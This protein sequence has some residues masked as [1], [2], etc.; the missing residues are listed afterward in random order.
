MSTPVTFVILMQSPAQ[1]PVLQ[2][3][4]EG[5]LCSAVWQAAVSPDGIR[6]GSIVPTDDPGEPQ[7]HDR[8]SVS[9]TSRRTKLVHL[10]YKR[11]GPYNFSEPRGHPDQNHQN[12][13]TR[14]FPIDSTT[15]Y[16]VLTRIKIGVRRFSRRTFRTPSVMP[17]TPKLRKIGGRYPLSPG[18]RAR[19]RDKLVLPSRTS[20]HEAPET[21]RSLVSKLSPAQN[22]QNRRTRR[23]SADSTTLYQSLTTNENRRTPIFSTHFLTFPLSHLLAR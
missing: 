11:W 7:E 14:Q 9:G 2:S 15:L 6:Q 4:H 12:R 8:A 3:T 17:M 23:F 16:R 21:S 18:E 19:V 5:Q 13:R 20:L 1:K 10:L 22:H